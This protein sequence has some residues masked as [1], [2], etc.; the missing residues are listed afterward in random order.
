MAINKRENVCYNNFIT[1]ITGGKL[2]MKKWS[3]IVLSAVM[4]A[5]MLTTAASAKAG[6][7]KFNTLAVTK[8]PVQ[9]GKVTQAE[10]GGN[11]PIVLDGSGKNTEGTW[12]NTKWDKEVLKF[13]FTWDATNLYLGLTVEGDTTESQKNC[14]AAGAGNVCPFGKCDSIQIGFNP[15][16]IVKGQH[17]VLF[18][19]GFTAGGQP[20][21]HADAYRSEKD[22]EQAKEYTS[23][24]KG[25]SSK[26]SATGFNYQVELVFPWK[27][28]FVKG[29][30]R[31][32]EGAKVFDMSAQKAAAGYELPVFLVYTD[33]DLAANKN[34]YIRTDSTTGNKWVG[35]EMS[36]LALV[37]KDAPVAATTAKAAATTAKAAATTK[38]SAPQTLDASVVMF[39][40]AGI[41][42][43]LT[44]VLAKKKK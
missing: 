3:K 19:V 36:S 32:N 11:A 17:P 39:A 26:Y 2:I 8:A 20:F 15:G 44:A 31:S 29:A 4:A 5:L 27:E 6:E 37:L 41:S 16:Y 10:Y 38:A 25:Y 12:A 33:N 22:G 14:P 13:Y 9:D 1:K 30:G 35:E 43:C 21:V 40:A 34:I 42:G 24:I 7:I 18:C 28:I 23:N